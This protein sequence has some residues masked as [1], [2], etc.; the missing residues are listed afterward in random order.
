MLV[1]AIQ[2]F[3]YFIKIFKTGNSVRSVQKKSGPNNVRTAF[4]IF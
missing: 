2:S 4:N 1:T 3:A